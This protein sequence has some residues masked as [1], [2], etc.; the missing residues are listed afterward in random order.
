MTKE[1]TK[2]LAY[3]YRD[4]GPLKEILVFDHVDF[5]EAGTQVVGG[6]VEPGEDLREA[7]LR[8]ILE[9]AGLVFHIVDVHPIGQTVYE[10]KDRPEKNHRHYFMIEGSHLEDEWIHV[11]DSTGADHGLKFR[12]FWIKASEA[13][14]MLT[15]SMG[16]LVDRV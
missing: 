1:K 16:E 2:V 7:L 15:G 8:E 11:V 13:L 12:F 3:I 4:V 9:E 10:R 6:T 14:T 5:K